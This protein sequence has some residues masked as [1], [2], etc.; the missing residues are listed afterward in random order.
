MIK[1]IKCVL[2]QCSIIVLDCC[3][4]ISD[5]LFTDR[6]QEIRCL[7]RTQQSYEEESDAMSKQIK[8]LQVCFSSI[9]RL[10]DNSVNSIYMSALPLGQEFSLNNTVKTHLLLCLKNDLRILYSKALK[11]F[12][13][14]QTLFNCPGGRFI[15]DPRYH[16]G[17][18][19]LSM[20]N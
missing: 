20:A 12:H 14:L 13:R 2:L 18:F 8:E 10:N 1:K 15:K 19:V 5:V 9:S 4:T 7:R 17:P 16:Y 3:L 11:Y 6:E